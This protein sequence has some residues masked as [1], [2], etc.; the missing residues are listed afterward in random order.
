VNT[1]A[2]HPD[3]NHVEQGLEGHATIEHPD[4]LVDREADLLTGLNQPF[5]RKV[6]VFVM[7]LT[8]SVETPL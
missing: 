7:C 5:D 3:L 4:K 8:E 6:H 2:R 1:R